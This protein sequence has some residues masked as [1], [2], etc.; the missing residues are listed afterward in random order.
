M[1]Q[2]LHITITTHPKAC[3]VAV[4]VMCAAQS[5]CAAPAKS[6]LMDR[7]AATSAA[8]SERHTLS[9]VLMAAAAGVHMTSAIAKSAGILRVVRHNVGI[10]AVR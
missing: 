10:I 5:A 4:L 8:S 7:G 1:V 6:V 3:R 2:A 9:G